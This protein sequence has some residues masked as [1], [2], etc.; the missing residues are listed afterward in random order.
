MASKSHFVD[1]YDP[2]IEDSYRKQ[3]M[4]DDE[5]ALLDVL[6]TAGQEEYSAMREQYMR[7]GEGFL[8][9]YSITSRQSFEEITTFQQQILRVKDKDYFP[10]V[11]VGNKCDLESEREVPRSE[12]EALAKS[13]GCSFIETSAKSRINVDKAFYD[14]VREIRRYNKEMQPNPSGGGANG[15][16]APPN[17]M[18]VEDGEADAG[19]CSKCVVL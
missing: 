15:G 13:F 11:V 6:D 1:E 19:C 7:T 5:V 9:V 17:K 2:T 16:S 18:N 10:M 8:L 3:C 4:I 14:I 12:G